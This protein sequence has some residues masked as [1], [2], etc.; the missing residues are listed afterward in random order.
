VVIVTVY[1]TYLHDPRLALA[2]GHVIK[3]CFAPA[4]LKEQIS[5]ALS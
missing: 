5:K 2:N 1:D 4:E 3:T